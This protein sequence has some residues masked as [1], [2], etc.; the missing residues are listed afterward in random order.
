MDQP[1][2]SMTGVGFAAGP[3]ELGEVRIE[4]RTV[5]GR[6]AS[7]KLRLP[8][9]GGGYEAAIEEAVRAVVR[10]GTATVVVER[11]Q[12][13][14]VLPDHDVVLAT[15]AELR[16][17]AHELGLAPPGLADVLQQASAAGRGD[18]RTSRPLPQQLR[19]LLDR[20][21][22]DL[23]AHRRADGA[24]TVGAVRA[25]LDR[26]AAACREI[27]ARAPQLV[28]HHRERL[29]QRVRE[30]VARH[31]PEAPPAVDVV[32][33]VAAFADRVDVAEELQR[34]DAHTAAV[35][36]VLERGG[37]IGRRLEFLLQELQRE[38]NTLGAKSPDTTIAH[39]VVGMKACLERIK[40]QVANLE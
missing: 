32:R 12:A 33:E 19:A 34:L 15:A 30:F 8:P 10:R 13:G 17:L 7:V 38:T 3:C 18:G 4:V 35:R 39:V 31:L 36:S 16:R 9:A 21:L 20:A 27:A 40:E 24:G 11:V 37:E 14:A 6:G 2:H 25:D 26:F 28:E 22:A 1:T 23:A 29:L 5:N